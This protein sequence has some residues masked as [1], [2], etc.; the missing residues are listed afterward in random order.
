MIVEFQTPGPQE[1]C[2]DYKIDE[3]SSE[4]VSKVPLIITIALGIL[5]GILIFVFIAAAVYCYFVRRR[6]ESGKPAFLFRKGKGEVVE[7]QPLEESAEEVGKMEAI[8]TEKEKTADDPVPAVDDVNAESLTG[9]VY[10]DTTT[11]TS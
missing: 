1:L 6:G 2:A 11:A 4:N 10:N 9:P 8:P 5:I 7:A 3:F